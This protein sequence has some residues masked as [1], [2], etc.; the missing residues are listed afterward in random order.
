[1]IKSFQDSYQEASEVRLSYQL[2]LF[3]VI[4][5]SKYKVCILQETVLQFFINHDEIIVPPALL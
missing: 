4:Y 5:W 1:M 3:H 2:I